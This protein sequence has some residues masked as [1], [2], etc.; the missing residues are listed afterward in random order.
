MDSPVQLFYLIMKGETR[1]IQ[2]SNRLIGFDCP[3]MPFDDSKAKGDQFKN[4]TDS[5]DLTVQLCHLIRKGKNVA[6]S[7]H[8]I[9]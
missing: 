9:D 5:L 8:Q 6:N 4:Q 1:P 2:K 3:T 7:K